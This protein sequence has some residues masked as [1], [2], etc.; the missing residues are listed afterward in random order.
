[1]TLNEEVHDFIHKY[2]CRGVPPIAGRN[3]LEKRMEILNYRCV[4][5]DAL[6]Q[7]YYSNYA[8]KFWVFKRIFLINLIFSC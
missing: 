8:N 2:I 6:L 1:M 4:L 3:F 5:V 7:E